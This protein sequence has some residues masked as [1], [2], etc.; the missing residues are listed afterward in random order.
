[1]DREQV[2]GEIT[3]NAGQ[4]WKLMFNC[5]HQSIHAGLPTRAQFGILFMVARHG[6]Q[7]IKQIAVNF[8]ISSSAITQIVDTLVNDGYLLRRADDAD[9]RK[10]CIDITEEGKKILTE[11]KKLRL[12]RMRAM[13]EAISDEELGQ[14]NSIY[15]KIIDHQFKV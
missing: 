12:K 9:R 1:M 8:G 6:Q 7:N 15:T 13:F 11:A 5:D 2:L 4:I 3:E 14:L 10:I